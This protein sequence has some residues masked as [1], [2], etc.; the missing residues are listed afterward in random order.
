MSVYSLHLTIRAQEDI[1]QFWDYVPQDYW[2]PAERFIDSLLER[3]QDLAG[4][5]Y[6]GPPDAELIDVHAL[7]VGRF[8]VFY[9]V[10]ESTRT[11]MILRFWDTHRDLPI[12]EDLSG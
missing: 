1:N 12:W 10:N 5:P 8:K 11:V 9:T 3:T 2:E 6:M 4:F 7:V